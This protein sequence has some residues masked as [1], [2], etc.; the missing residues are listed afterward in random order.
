MDDLTPKKNCS[1]G[2]GYVKLAPRVILI[3]NELKRFIYVG[4]TNC[5]KFI[6]CSDLYTSVR[7][8]VVITRKDH[9]DL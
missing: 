5:F 8:G 3:C 1:G 4:N 9:C 6:F 7:L 2:A